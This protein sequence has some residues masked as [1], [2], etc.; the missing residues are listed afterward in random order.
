MTNR[1]V[2]DE[3]E[4]M[5]RPALDDVVGAVDPPA[6]LAER[7]LA[8]VPA[9]RRPVTR[10][11]GARRGRRFLLPL[12]AAASIIAIAVALALVANSSSS[13]HR[14]PPAHTKTAAPPKPAALPHFRAG[15]IEFSDP[16]HGWALGDAQC[17]SS[18]KTNCP[19][20]LATSDGGKSWHSLSVPSGLVSTFSESSCGTNGRVTGPC[21]DNVLFANAS[22]GYLWSLHELY[23]TT[24]GG[25]SWR[26]YA[27]PAHEWDGA[28]QLVVAG[29][30]VVRLAPIDPCSSGCPGAVETAPVGT[31][32]WQVSTP[33]HAHVGLFSSSLTARG[34]DL[35]LFAGNSF[36][37][38]SPG[39]YRSSD[40][41]HRWHR[42]ARDICGVAGS[43]EQDPFSGAGS[44]VA[45]NGALIARCLNGGRSGSIRVASPGT[46]AFSA[47]RRLPGADTVAVEAAQSEQR[48]VVADVSRAYA[49]ARSQATFYTTT[50]GGRSWQR[51]ATLPVA[52]G[53]VWFTSGRHGYAVASDGAGYFATTDGGITWREEAFSA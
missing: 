34:R 24:D 48:V 52:G 44:A 1:S 45:D 35:Y 49:G 23:W 40:G 41:G 11:D 21:V 27:D 19:A 20:L 39:I 50:D 31:T 22:D 37:G 17:A 28:A 43:A 53:T 36:A 30:A 29:D 12:L 15:D 8:E 51:A 32:D 2:S 7:L 42:L 26:Q 4:Q 9:G 13:E 33:A 14:I 16:R 18:A 10:L 3:F 5:L 38:A 46:S 25:R 6:G 47:A